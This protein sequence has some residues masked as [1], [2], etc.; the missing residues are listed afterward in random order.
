MNTSTIPRS[1]PRWKPGISMPPKPPCAPISNAVSACS[2]RPN[3]AGVMARG[4]ADGPIR[5]RAFCTLCKSRCGAIYTVE[6]GRLTGVDPD[7]DHPTGGALCAKGR[8]VPE[9]VHHTNRLTRPLRR[10]NP[11]T[12]PVPQWEEIS[13]DEALDQIAARMAAIRDA[14]GAE[15]VG[16]ATTT[17][18]GTAISDSID[19]IMRLVWD[20]GSPNLIAAVEVC[21]FQKDY[22][23]AL[24]FGQPLGAPDYG[25]ADTI[26]LWGHN[27]A[28]TWLAQAQRIAEARQRGAKVVV[29][30]PKRGGSG[31]QADLWLRIRPGADAALAMGAIGHLLDR[32]LFDRDFV[33]DWTDAAFLIDLDSDTRLDAATLGNAPGF[34]IRRGDGFEPL[35]PA[36]TAGVPEDA[37]LWFDG[38][39]TDPAGGRRRVSTALALLRRNSAGWTPDKVSEATGIPQDQL[40]AFYDILACSGPL[41]YYH[42]TGFAQGLAATQTTRAVSSLFALRGD[43]DAPGGNRWLSGPPL[44]PI[45]DPSALPTQQRD[46]ALGVGDLP[47]GPPRH[48]FVTLRD[49]CA[50]IEG[51]APDRMRML[52]G[53]GS[54]LLTSHPDAARTRRALSALDFHVHCDL[55]MTPMAEMADIVLPVTASLEH[56]AL[57]TGFEI[58]DRAVGHVQFRPALLPPPG[59]A[60]PDYRIARA[61]A[62][63]LGLDA[64]PWRLPF[65]DALDRMLAPTGLTV[66]RL[67]Q[68]PE[69]VTLDIPQAPRRY[70][71][72]DAE[73]RPNGFR[74]PSRR[75]EFHSTDLRRHGYPPMATAPAPLPRD[76]A[77]PILLSTAKSGYYTHSSLRNLASLRRKSPDPAIEI[78]PALATR[79]GLQDHDWAIVTTAM[80]EVR[81]RV[82]LDGDLAEDVAIAEFG[83][84][85]GCDATGAGDLPVTGERSANINAIL[86][87]ATRDPVSGA[88]PLREARCSLRRDDAASRGGWTGARAFTITAREVLANDVLHLRICPVDGGPLP[89][90]RPG[91]HVGLSVPGFDGR[92]YYS[93]IGDGTPATHW[94]IAVCRN[95]QGMPGT[96][97]SRRLHDPGLGDRLLLTPPTGSFIV[98]PDIDR[99]V[100]CIAGGIGITPFLSAIRA[101]RHARSQAPFV[102]HYVVPDRDSAP[103]WQE[104]ARLADTLPRLSVRLWPRRAPR[105]GP[106]PGLDGMEAGAD[107]A[108]IAAAIDTDLLKRRPLIFLC[109]PEGL[110][111]GMRATLVARGVPTADIATEVFKSPLPIPQDIPP[112]SVTLARS[113]Q[114]FPWTPAMG[115]ILSAA[116]A[117]GIALPS[118]CQVGQCES[119]AVRVLTGRVLSRADTD[120]PQDRCLTCQAVPLGDITLDL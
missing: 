42:W 114:S 90:F 100:I 46:K 98:P 19:W 24:T 18:S 65:H 49:V 13:W 50:S 89:S 22:A 35:D 108:R 64:A 95:P 72:R 55:F 25:R 47:L 29:I 113:G 99:P 37:D 34:V 96:S 115:S 116:T 120:L 112:A 52:L 61:L 15:A 45:A 6:N 10:R 103:F 105:R 106:H 81:L 93:L 73:G 5:T 20:F 88:P 60:R 94:D 12:D 23:Q 74:T 16:F 75:I 21:N 82:R 57:R 86:S 41:S 56:D 111:D 53:F 68:S 4:T 78:S 17:P 97:L 104:I 107:P 92:R 67:R 80:G 91:Q 83:W 119:C 48:G 58:S 85:Q 118:G 2:C 30:D 27:P 109:G 1:S 44:R 79:H 9:I 28:R 51:D 11:R 26:V 84:W 69:G 66:A 36:T 63:R 76:P 38:T 39:L 14:H 54:N 7:P 102:L 8:A 59:E 3:E 33:R 117:A 43:V 87:D 40:A 77:F 101:L 70:A 32:G 62:R 110:T 71:D 31:E